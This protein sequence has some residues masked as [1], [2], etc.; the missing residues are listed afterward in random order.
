MFNVPFRLSL[1]LV[2]LLATFLLP[3]SAAEAQSTSEL[4]QEN[5]RLR[6]RVAD[7]ERELEQAR[8]ENGELQTEIERLEQL[9]EELQAG[10]SARPGDPSQARPEKVVT[11]DESEPWASPRALLAAL[12]TAYEEQLGELEMGDR[13][14][15]VPRNVYMRELRKWTAGVN[16]EY[17]APIQWHVRVVAPLTF[18]NNQYRIELQAVD[19]KTD[20]QLGDAFEAFLSRREARRLQERAE[21]YSADDALVLKGILIPRVRI[22]EDR[23]TAGPFNNPPLVGPFAELTMAVDLQSLL[24]APEPKAEPEEDRQPDEDNGSDEQ[25]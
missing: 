6:S 18:Q 10:A 9:L 11:I 25:R 19:P 13:P 8:A 7:L 4:R 21:R 5:Q 14:G 16:R 1:P 12:Q 23:A 22:N 15:D 17:R 2:T 24:P 3:A 20:V